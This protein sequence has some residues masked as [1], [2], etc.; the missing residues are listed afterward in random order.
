MLYE[1]V[2]TVNKK[3]LLCWVYRTSYSIEIGTL[4]NWRNLKIR[5][6]CQFLLYDLLILWFCENSSILTHLWME[7][8]YL[9][10]ELILIICLIWIL[11]F[12][13]KVEELE[14]EIL[15]SKE[16]IEFCRTKMQELVS[17][18]ILVIMHLIIFNAFPPTFPFVSLWLW[19]WGVQNRINLVPSRCLYDVC[20]NCLK[21]WCC[22][23]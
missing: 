19:W 18:S 20:Y 16:K 4:V 12:S 21:L 22:L 2:W 8:P 1:Q 23:F 15:D 5:H 14:K 7:Y 10:N 17:I 6:F 11:F 9:W 3:K 13:W